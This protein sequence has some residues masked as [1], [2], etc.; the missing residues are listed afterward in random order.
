[1]KRRD[2]LKIIPL[3]VACLQGFS[4]I[5]NAALKDKESIPYAEVKLYNGTPTLFLNG[6]PIYYSGMWVTTPS[7][8]SWGHAKESWPHPHGGDSD[9]AQRTAETGVHI[10][11]FG[12][13]DEWIGPDSYDFSTVEARFNQII[14]TD[15]L[16]RFHLRILLDNKRWWQQTYP[17]EC[18]ITSEMIRPEP[19]YAS[20]VWRK[21]A[22]KFLREY[23]E[24]LK[25][26]GMFD[27][28]IAYQPMAGE[29]GEWTRF[30]SSGAAPCGDYSEPMRR[31]FCS[32]LR[33]HYNEDERAFKAA[34]NK[35]DITF[36]TAE[37]PS[38]AE[39]LHTKNW[40]LRDPT[41]EQNVID[42]FR[43]LA[44]RCSDLVIDFC[45]TIKET[46]NGMALAG[47]FYGYTMT[48]AYNEVFYNQGRHAATEYSH[49]QRGGHLGFYKVLNSSFVDF[50]VSPT[51][52]GFR[53]I[54]G[55]APSAFL[56]DSVRLHNKLLIIE[57]DT[58][59]HDTPFHTRYGRAKNLEESTT[60]LRRNFSHVLTRGL[61]SW[62][63]P[64]GDPDLL[65]ILK[66][67]N[68]L[69]QFSLN[70]ERPLNAEVAVLVDEESQF[71]EQ[72]KY[73][74][75]LASVSH[76]ILRGMNR[77][78]APFDLYHL[79]DLIYGQMPPYKLYLFLNVYRLNTIQRE[80]LKQELRKDGR[81]AVWIYAPGYFNNDSS[82]DNM[83][84]ITGF[85]FEKSDLPWPPFMHIVNFSHPVTKDIPQDLF[86]DFN[87]ALGPLFCVQDDDAVTLGEVVYAQGSCVPG[88][89]VKS[90][91]EWTSIYCSVPNIPAPILRGIARYANV[92]LYS[93]AGD[94]LHLSQQLFGVHT[95]SGGERVFK[96][97]HGVEVIYDLF[98]NKSIGSN[99]DLFKVTLSPASSE[100]YFT[101]DRDTLSKLKT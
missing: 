46:T 60:I 18:E 8:D 9:T 63:A 28:V 101:G 87:D 30:H 57:N 98:N 40:T 75:N 33:S 54:G 95:V 42:Y 65:S 73:N 79:N 97:P 70:T 68:R 24:H 78:G 32:W 74:L 45:R 86:W 55:D 4:G 84:D 48:C 21:G 67:F 37:V 11:V 66:Q 59:L 93:D 2:T 29:T 12:I 14:K 49:N 43:C 13:G 69:G 23:I 20:E 7:A 6:K 36:D 56:T 44:D 26:I 85:R 89:C 92:H 38:E 81:T 61:G 58:R 17:D 15:P 25:R 50:V 1:M 100:L 90:F 34:W 80:K 96:L 41:P 19:S 64:Y 39:Q 62:A 3:S 51:H 99:T 77:F 88:L 22:N 72:I 76:Q 5:I 71:Y 35:P 82:V 31:C 27:R 52:Y 83:T 47:A 10:Y 91:S 94:V 16:A 53:G